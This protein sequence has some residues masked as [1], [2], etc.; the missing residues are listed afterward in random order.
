MIKRLKINNCSQRGMALILVLA[1]LAL[2]GLTIAGSLNYSTTIL[3]DNR[4]SGY[5]M[6]CMYSA[7][8]GV[9]YAI[10]ALENDEAI[11]EF[12]SDNVNGKMISLDIEDKGIFKFYCGDLMYVGSLRSEE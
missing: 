2:G 9:E 3:Y 7:G 6:D 1:L 10:W 11:P 5:A 12:L 8:A 4:I